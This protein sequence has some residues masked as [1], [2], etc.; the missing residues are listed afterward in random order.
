[1]RGRIL[2]VDDQLRARRVLVNELEDAGFEVSEARDGVD[3]WKAFQHQNPDVVIT[4]MVMPRADGLELLSRIRACSETPVIVFTAHG[5]AQTATSAFKLGAEDFVC[6]PD[7]EIDELVALV[8]TAAG[9]TSPIPHHPGFG[10]RLAGGSRTMERLRERLTGL[11]PLRAPVLVGG[12]SG[13]GRS[14]TALALHDLGSSAGGPLVRLSPR[15][16]LLEPRSPEPAAVHLDGIERFSA[17]ARQHWAERI[18]RAEA[19]GFRAGPRILASATGSILDLSLDEAFASSLGKTLLRFAIELP[20]LREI[21]EDIPAIAEALMDRTGSAVGRAI[22]LS[23]AA[24]TFL[25]EQ[26]WPGN[27]GQLER[28]LERSISFS[29]GRQVRRDVV[30]DVLADLEESLDGIRARERVRERNELLRILQ[31]TG[32]NITRA[33]EEFGRSRAAVYRLIEKHGIPLRRPRR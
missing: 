1:M 4:D 32:G 2:V 23:P 11:A 9:E 3:A 15:R 28:V 12:E 17:E 13:T 25:C 7:V 29:R 31:E 14:T 16:P 6:S 10:E 22:R 26:R 30:A 19:E 18:A 27:A 20:P 24:V 21:P 5:T 33:A 8:A